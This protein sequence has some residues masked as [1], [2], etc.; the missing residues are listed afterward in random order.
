[1]DRT[2]KLNS[3]ANMMIDKVI[4]LC[5]YASKYKQLQGNTGAL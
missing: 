4:Y 5:H 2:M 3:C 1:M